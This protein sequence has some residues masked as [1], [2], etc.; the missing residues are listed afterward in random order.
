MLDELMTLCSLSGAS[1]YED[2]VRVYI[3]QR[4]M[5]HADSIDTDA[6]GNLIVFKKTSPGA[7]GHALRPHGR[8]RPHHHRL[9]RG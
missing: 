8:G 6:L 4:I 9:R 7:Q 1:G 5:K 3:L 2:D